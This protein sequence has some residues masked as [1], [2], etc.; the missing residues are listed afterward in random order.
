VTAR[1]D[2]PERLAVSIE[3]AA[4]MIG[5]RRTTA[6]KLIRNGQ[7]PTITLGRRRLVRVEDLRLYVAA[8]PVANSLPSTREVSSGGTESSLDLIS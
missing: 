3:T 4:R 5:C 7:L 2:S 8:L 6:Y 1:G